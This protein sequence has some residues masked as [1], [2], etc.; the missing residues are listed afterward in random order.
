MRK[1]NLKE[2]SVPSTQRLITRESKQLQKAPEVVGHETEV[3]FERDR[4]VQSYDAEG[5]AISSHDL[6]LPVRHALGGQH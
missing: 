5:N 1:E 4:I 2:A 6:S 3:V